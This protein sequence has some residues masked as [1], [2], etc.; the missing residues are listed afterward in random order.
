MGAAPRANFWP[1]SL[2]TRFGSGTQ[3]AGLSPRSVENSGLA[4]RV[5]L[6]ELRSLW[7]KP[8]S[9]V[10]HKVARY[11]SYSICDV[12][13]RAYPTLAEPSKSRF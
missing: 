11:F 12:P 4:N 13:R 7:T 3:A 6:V 8:S 5:L 9:S 10:S 1:T 2:P